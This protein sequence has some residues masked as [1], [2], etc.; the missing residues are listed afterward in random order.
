MTPVQEFLS[1]VHA[2][3]VERVRTLLGGHAEVRSQPGGGTE[4]ELTL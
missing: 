4:V 3:D 2:G 1:A